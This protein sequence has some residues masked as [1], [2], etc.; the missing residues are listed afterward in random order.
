VCQCIPSQAE[1]ADLLILEYQQLKEEQRLRIASRDNLV[2]ATLVAI[3]TVVA[4]AY[5]FTSSAILL[6]LPP[7]CVILG[8]T[9]TT[10]D[11]KV[12]QIGRHIRGTLAAQAALHSHP[13][14]PFAWEA[15][16]RHADGYRLYA[17]IQAGVTLLTFCGPGIIAILANGTII[18]AS[19]TVLTVAT[20]E[21]IA[22]AVL[23][24]MMLT[25]RD[26]PPDA[27]DS[28]VS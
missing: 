27:P 6:L 4:A 18:A 24:C 23:G 22:L 16:H 26:R 3:G 12:W 7:V 11:R 5:Q 20:A 21:A 19:P 2:Y 8:W 10:N 17:S 25:N 14:G 28:D 13:S 9:H 15:A 1:T